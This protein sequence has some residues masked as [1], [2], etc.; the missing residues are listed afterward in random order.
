MRCGNESRSPCECVVTRSIALGQGET[1]E[2]EVKRPPSDQPQYVYFPFELKGAKDNLLLNLEYDKAD[3][4]N[5]LE[6]GLFG[7]EFS[8]NNSMEKKGF[9]GWSGS[10]LDFFILDYR[11]PLYNSPGYIDRLF[12]DGKWH[13]IVGIAE[14][15]GASVRLKVSVKKDYSD[16]HSPLRKFVRAKNTIKI[17]KAEPSFLKSPKG[18]LRGDLHTHTVHS[19]GQ[20]S[21]EGILEASK[22]SGLDFVSITEHNTLTH[23]YEIDKL[24]PK[25]PKLQILKGQ[26]ITTHGGHINIWGLDT[27]DWAEFRYV[28]NDKSVAA[29]IKKEADSLDALASINH[30]TMQCKGCNFTFGEWEELGIVEVWNAGW[31]SQDEEVLKMWDELLRQGKR[32]T[33]IGSSDTHQPPYMPS[34]WG[35]NLSPG[36]P[37]LYVKAPKNNEAELFKGLRAGK[38][39]VTSKPT[40]TVVFESENGI[41]IGETVK[42]LGKIKFKAELKGFKKG[43]K[44]VLVTSQ[45]DSRPPIIIESDCHTV[46]FPVSF[47]INGYVRLEVRNADGSMAAFTNPIWVGK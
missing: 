13:L 15:D 4:K 17:E 30:P 46:G 34:R 22:M 21:I 29:K 25:F 14:M 8:G 12:K 42:R 16:D 23:H 33:A 28:E 18:W 2:V 9:R 44:M 26:E 31:D 32:V 7:P 41:G 19:D 5:R 27:G 36:Y 43:S 10:I 24:A 38:A 1:W 11:N 47:A 6:F 3:G 39:Y 35:T 40:Q 37:S 45:K 20:W